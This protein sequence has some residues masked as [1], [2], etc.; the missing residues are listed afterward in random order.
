MGFIVSTEQSCSFSLALHCS[1]QLFI[2]SL[3]DKMPLCLHLYISPCSVCFCVPSTTVLLR[4]SLRPSLRPS[5]SLSVCYITGRPLLFSLCSS[6][7]NLRCRF[8]PGWLSSA[9]A[10]LYSRVGCVAAAP[11]VQGGT[12]EMLSPPGQKH[13]ETHRVIQAE[14]R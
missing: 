11:P 7:I 5:V 14:W 13:D 4:L 9:T 6:L 10:C 2:S 1:S 3:M 12:Q 8:D